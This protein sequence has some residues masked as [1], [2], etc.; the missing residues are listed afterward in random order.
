MIKRI[1]G[2]YC[3]S[4]TAEKIAA[5]AHGDL[6]RSKSGRYFLHT[7]GAEIK[8]NGA[9]HSVENITLLSNGEA[10]RRWAKENL[11][12]K[13]YAAFEQPSKASS[14]FSVS[15]SP[16]AREKLYAERER[17]GDT[18]MAILDGLIQKNL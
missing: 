16:M 17:T 9:R 18:I 10:A 15:V 4:E 5:S 14:R 8:A 6:Y 2:V 13:E 11:S 12:E 1:D 7:R 3:N